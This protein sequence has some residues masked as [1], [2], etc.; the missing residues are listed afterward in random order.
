MNKKCAL[1][2][3]LFILLTTGVESSEPSQPIPP[4]LE[5]VSCLGINKEPYHAT[6]MPYADLRQALAGQRHA[7]SYCQSLNGHWKFCW[8][9]RPEERPLEFYKPEFDSSKWA[10]IPVPSNWEVHGY[11]TPFYRNFGY[12]INKDYPR[13]MTKPPGHWTAMIERNPVGSYIR[14]FSLPETW[15]GRRVFVTFD[16]VDSAFFVFVNGIKVGYSV[17]SRNPAEFD[18]TTHLKTGENTIAV[19]VY[20]YS[21]G[22]WLEDQ[23]MFRLHGIYR[24]VTLWSVPEVHIRDFFAK[25]DLDQKYQDGTLT[26]TS[27]VRNYSN[28]PQPKLQLLAQ[29][30]DAQGKLITKSIA[31]LKEFAAKQEQTSTTS[32]NIEAPSK[33]TAETPNL[34]TLVLSTHRE[35]TDIPEELI[36][37]RVGFR[38][39]EIHGRIF[40]VNGVPI[41]L[42]GVNRHEH[43]SD[44]GH[45]ITESQMIRDIEVIKQGNCNHVR[46]SHYTND[47]RWYELCDEYGLWL[48]AEANVESH[49]FG[50]VEKSLSHKPELEAAHVDRNIANVENVKNHPSVIIYSLGNEAGSGKNFHAALKAIKAIDETRPVHYQGFEIGEKNPADID[51][52]W[53]HDAGFHE[54]AARDKKLKKPYYITE[55]AHAMFNSMG[56]LKEFSIVMD[57]NPS[58]LGGAIWE[59]QD[60]GLWNKRDPKRPILAYG[61]G[62]KEQPNNEYFIHKGVVSWNRE[63]E[64]KNAKPNFPEMKK[65]FQWVD[66]QLSEAK[67]AIKISNKYQFT[68]LSKF[69]TR[70]SLSKDGNI[71]EQGSIDTPPIAALGNGIMN[72]PFKAPEAESLSEYF[73]RISMHTREA[74][75]WSKKGHEIASE[76]FQVK[77]SAK[78]IIPFSSTLEPIQ[79]SENENE[80]YIKGS[81]FL[82]VFNKTTGFMTGLEKQGLQLLAVNG[83]PVLHLWR[84]LHRDDDVWLDK[85]WKEKGIYELQHKIASFN[86]KQSDPST[87]LVESKIQIEGKNGFGGTHTVVYT[88]RGDGTIHVDNQT[89]FNDIKVP[90]ARMGVRLQVNPT[91]T[92][93]NFYGRG[94]HENY[95]D[96]KSG[97][98]IGIYSVNIHDQYQYEKPMEYGNHED[99]RWGTVKGAKWPGICISSTGAPIQLSAIPYTD[100]EM[101]PVKYK[102]DLPP[103]KA[104]V[105]AIGANTLGVGSA[106]CGEKPLKPYMVYTTP[107]SFS[108]MISLLNKER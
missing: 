42:K 1:F 49:G 105:I 55:F 48:L 14:K 37:C 85:P 78:P 106:S 5:D 13:I 88:V 15:K 38:K 3:L 54:Q 36:S 59:F 2:G 65:C 17:N 28:N 60:Q 66:F 103:S 101:T 4:E 7:S 19:E 51:A 16:G 108:Y 8:V 73:L 9:P 10:D 41:K 34:Y 86:F 67:G 44:V 102:I 52:R 22:T 97:A 47:P 64:G 46:T 57:R 90:I 30:F 27:K 99:V 20:Q 35:G 12:T 100:E 50:W 6:L 56:S 92:E 11:G 53:Y 33:W 95:S 68:D 83:G 96:R 87:I 18:L 23:D 58:L 93:L 84:A 69:E 43:W 82:V 81:D 25:P 61:G 104:T 39:V 79:L 62:F 63:L 26:I 31:L 94:P 107:A 80:I 71:I 91:L 29:L 98:D 75:S 72:I 76:Q 70:W 74:T 24:N 40:L 77:S 21:S 32:L 89:S 45:A